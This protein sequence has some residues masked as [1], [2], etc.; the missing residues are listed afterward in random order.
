[1]LSSTTFGSIKISLTSSGWDLN[2]IDVI[3]VLIHTDFPDPVAPAIN[4]W[5]I[6]SIED[7]TALPAISFPNAKGNFELLSKR[8]LMIKFLL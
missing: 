7:T 2:N 4:R 6:L 8:L 3:R 5:G 1:M